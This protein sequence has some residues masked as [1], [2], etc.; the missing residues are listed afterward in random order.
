MRPLEMIWY[1]VLPS[2]FPRPLPV[3][4]W[5]GSWNC[6]LLA[7]DTVPEVSTTRAHSAMNASL[8]TSSAETC[9]LPKV[10][11]PSVWRPEFT[12]TAVPHTM[13]SFLRM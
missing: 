10:A 13:V 1:W 4:G 11:D 2:G 9:E 8:S 7:T 5:N 3:V 6:V 12:S